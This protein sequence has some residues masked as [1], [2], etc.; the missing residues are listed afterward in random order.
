M[1]DKVIVGLGYVARAGKDT[2]AD[3]LV[4]EYGFRKTS[5]ATSLKEGIGR[6]VFGLND[7]QLYGD[8]KEVVEDFWNERLDI[9]EITYTDGST[10]TVCD[11]E[12]KFKHH[13]NHDHVSEYKRLPV[14]PRLILQL[15]GTE[16]GRR[17]FGECLWVETVG[18]RI[19][20][21]DHDRWVIPDVRFP[22]EVRAVL[23]W[24]GYAYEVKREIA[25]AT[26]GTK[27]HASE[28][29]LQTFSDWTGIIQN[30][31][32]FDDLYKNVDEVIMSKI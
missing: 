5:F 27:G 8:K 3:H 4:K 30:N 15:A 26:G 16:G 28:T 7:D 11:F 2:I 25:Q 24:G 6:G 13:M 31:S 14:T 9:Y 20:A 19:A 32:T 12:E 1:Q 18:K 23:D 22:N 29:S 17:I 21:S 10:R